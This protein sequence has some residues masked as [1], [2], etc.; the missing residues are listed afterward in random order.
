M[1]VLYWQD[2]PSTLRCVSALYM[3]WLIELI[4]H[5]TVFCRQWQRL[6]L[7]AGPSLRQQDKVLTP[8]FVRPVQTCSDQT[9]MIFKSTVLIDNQG[10]KV[11]EVWG[12]R[13]IQVQGWNVSNW[14]WY[15][16]FSQWKVSL[17]RKR[18]TLC[19]T[20]RTAWGLTG[21]S[22]Q[23]WHILHLLQ[24]LATGGYHSIKSKCSKQ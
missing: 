15:L 10:E 12:N 4:P 21:S 7:N 18:H 14:R 2:P 3:W 8:P 11:H 17:V 6:S 24:R 23:F 19:S 1:K 13:S 9:Q 16:V 5:H 20:I 22:F